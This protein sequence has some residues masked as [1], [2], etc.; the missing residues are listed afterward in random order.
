MLSTT[1][2]TLQSQSHV[3][4]SK[5]NPQEKHYFICVDTSDISGLLRVS[6][7]P[8]VSALSL[9][10]GGQL[11]LCFVVHLLAVP[12]VTSPRFCLSEQ[13]QSCLRSQRRVPLCLNCW[14]HRIWRAFVVVCFDLLNHLIKLLGSQ[15]L[16]A[17]LSG[18]RF[19]VCHPYNF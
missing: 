19:H 18:L 9:Y 6:D 3:F 17:M 12:G 4:L 8:E 13:V 14:I 10:P 16:I 7:Q 15:P 1:K 5:Q 2:S 11:L